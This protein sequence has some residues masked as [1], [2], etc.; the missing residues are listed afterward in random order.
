MGQLLG[1]GGLWSAVDGVVSSL[2]GGLLADVQVQSVLADTVAQLVSAQLE[3][4]KLLRSWRIWWG[5]GRGGGGV[6]VDQSGGHRRV[7]CVVG[8]GADRF[9]GFDG[10]GGGV[11][12][13][14]WGG[15]GGFGCGD[16]VPDVAAQL[17][18]NP[19]VQAA[20]QLAVADPVGQLLGDTALWS[21]L[22]VW[23]GRWC[24]G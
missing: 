5:Q 17:Q 23:R 14:G 6:V 7:A 19:E 20:V 1:D 16:P 4:K 15:G 24:R 8:F 22:M 2:V 11:L 10:C 13:G 3:K 12:A 21:A 18:G 9:L